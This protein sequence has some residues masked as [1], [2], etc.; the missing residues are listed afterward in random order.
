MNTCLGEQSVGLLAASGNSLQLAIGQHPINGCSALLPPHAPSFLSSSTPDD[1]H[2]RTR[3]NRSYEWIGWIAGIPGFR[4]DSPDV[5]RATEH[6]LCFFCYFVEAVEV[7]GPH[8]EDVYVRWHGSRFATITRGPGH[9]DVCLGD[10]RYLDDQVGEHGERP[11]G[12]G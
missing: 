1:G 10:A 12:D 4:P 9:V 2:Q 5:D 8:D 3:L 7:S 11:V 6:H